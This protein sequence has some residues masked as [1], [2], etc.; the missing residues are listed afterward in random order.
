[1]RK[2]YRARLKRLIAV[3]RLKLHQLIAVFRLDL[4][5]FTPRVHVNVLL[6]KAVIRSKQSVDIIVSVGSTIANANA[7]AH[8]CR[9]AYTH[10]THIHI[11]TRTHALIPHSTHSTRMQTTHMQTAILDPAALLFY[12][13]AIGRTTV[14]CTVFLT[15]CHR[16]LRG[17]TQP[18][19]PCSARC[20]SACVAVPATVFLNV[21]YHGC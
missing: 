7:T 15:Q 10:N 3:S 19:S 18:V 13:S 14:P 8:T 17:A 6:S 5:A 4:H 20:Y 2:M 1:M 11:H 12:A 9:T 16:A 21:A